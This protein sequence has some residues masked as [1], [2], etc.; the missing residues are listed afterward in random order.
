MGQFRR[1]RHFPSAQMPVENPRA[2]DTQVENLRV[3]HTLPLMYATRARLLGRIHK[4]Q[5]MRHPNAQSVRVVGGGLA[6][7]ID[8][9]AKTNRVGQA[10]L[11]I[12]L[13]CRTCG[14]EAGTAHPVTRR[15]G[16]ACPAWT[17]PGVAEY[18]AAASTTP[19]RTSSK[20]FSTHLTFC[21]TVTF[22]RG[23]RFLLYPVVDVRYMAPFVVIGGSP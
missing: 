7:P 14:V 16:W 17:T 15:R 3:A 20:N 18:P 6:L 2:E 4:K 12:A 11:P 10:L 5:T 19:S 1:C 23:K 13:T 9:T 8:V 22:C 21:L